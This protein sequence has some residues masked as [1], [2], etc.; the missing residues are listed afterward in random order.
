VAVV[1]VSGTCMSGLD[2]TMLNVGLPTISHDFH[3][4][5]AQIGAVAVS[6][7]LTLAVFIPMAGWLGDR[8]GGRKIL[9]GSMA[10]FVIASILCGISQN[11][12]ELIISRALQGAAG[13]MMT[14]TG[15]AMLFRIVPPAERVRVVAM[16]TIPTAIAPALGPVLGGFF[17]DQLSWRYSFFVNVPIGAA[18]LAF[19][20]IFLP[21]EGGLDREPFD[22]RGFALILLGI[23]TFM[24]AVTEIPT[25]G[26]DDPL[27]LTLML[28]GLILLAAMVLVELRVDRPM[29][30]LRLLTNRLYREFNVTLALGMFIYSGWLFTVA[31]FYQNALGLSALEA[32]FFTLPQTIGVLFGAQ[33]GSRIVYRH[34]GPRRAVMV[35]YLNLAVWSSFLLLVTSKSDA[36]WMWITLFLTG[37]G[38]PSIFQ[39]AQAAAFAT[40]QKSDISRASTLTTSQRQIASA[41]GVALIS[42][43]TVL[44]WRGPRGSTV[45]GVGPYHIAFACQIGLALL[46]ALLISRVDDR[47]AAVTIPNRPA[48][49]KRLPDEQAD[50]RDRELLRAEA[51]ETEVEAAEGITPTSSVLHS[52]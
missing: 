1:Y 8:F 6:Y 12:P 39:S 25:R 47:E 10:L 7:L 2:S 31:Q 42:T 30:D 13:G 37:L 5:S 49:R 35:G 41:I 26:W 38:L 27:V 34:L 4:G 21:R 50:A 23:P 20:L 48:R 32:G 19:G 18:A 45:Q 29:I 9:L 43:V 52:E 11:L 22:F 24:Y 36:W 40:I 28:S 16:M 33:L 15:L 3:V 46:G 17:V 51:L 44:V 14:P